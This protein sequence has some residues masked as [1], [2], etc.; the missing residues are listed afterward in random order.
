MRVVAMF[1]LGVIG[2]S[3]TAWADDKKPAGEKWPAY[4]DGK[5]V[6]KTITFKPD[7]VE[8]LPARGRRAVT[9]VVFRIK[10]AT[11][12]ADY[13]TAGVFGHEKHAEELV[14]KYLKDRDGKI[15]VDAF[16][17]NLPVTK[18]E[19]TGDPDRWIEGRQMLGKLDPPIDPERGGPR[20]RHFTRWRRDTSRRY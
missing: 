18:K 9:T 19:W 6:H 16:W 13:V 3:A 5:Y 17:V 4:V 11:I 12:P 8:Y 1:A 20:E 2:I 14:T 7:K 15:T 10:D